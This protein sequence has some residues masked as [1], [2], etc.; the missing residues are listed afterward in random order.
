MAKLNNTMRKLQRAIIT[1][2]LIIKI[3]TSQFYSEEQK[4]IITVYI[5]STPYMTQNRNGDWKIRD[6]EI[7][8]SASQLEI[9]MCLKDIWEAVR[10]WR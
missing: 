8:R 10:E 7:L 3:G 1:K 4:R 9:T 6:L 2:R 5:L